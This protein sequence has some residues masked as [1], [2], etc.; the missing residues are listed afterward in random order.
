MFNYPIGIQLF[1]RPDY[2]RQM[3]KSLQRQ[4]L[5]VDTNKLYI[6]IDGFNGSIYEN[7]GASDQTQQ[8]ELISRQIFPNATIVREAKNLGIANLRNQ[9]QSAA[10]SGSDSWAAF[11]EEDL[12]L[13][14]T[15]LQELSD[16]ISIVDPYDEVSKVACFQ[17]IESLSSLPR[18]FEGFYP[19]RGTQ[20]VAER[21][22]F[23]ILKQPVIKKF[24]ELIEKDLGSYGQFKNSEI[25]SSMASF[26]YFLTY[27]QH[28]SLEEQIIH[29][30]G[31]LH[32]VSKPNLA[33]D[34]GIEGIHSYITNPIVLQN[35]PKIESLEIRKQNFKNQLP[36][37]SNESLDHNREYFAEILDGYHISKSRKLMLKKIFKRV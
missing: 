22:G 18:G 33:A 12:V 25:A 11:F 5:P 23:Y 19:G 7:N 26:G 27:F 1:N 29:S 31:K 4:T 37:V 36:E 8:V 13:D 16:L 34:I 32:V 20:A 15:Y 3:L 21:R 24:I 14:P 28:D 6:F 30:E 35:Q 2:T 9:L 10:F 17:I